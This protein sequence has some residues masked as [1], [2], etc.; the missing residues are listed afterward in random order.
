MQ[1][2]PSALLSA[3]CLLVA[4]SVFGDDC[5]LEIGRYEVLGGSEYFTTLE[6]LSEGKVILQHENWMPGHYEDRSTQR[7]A[8]T[9]SCGDTKV[10][11]SFGEKQYSATLQSVGPNPL[12][13]DEVARVLRFADTGKT[14]DV[15]DGGAFYYKENSLE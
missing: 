4:N 6:F 5:E 14:D 3:C 8:G 2:V 12:G 15:L 11:V 10:S 1:I 9:W 7:T 13:M